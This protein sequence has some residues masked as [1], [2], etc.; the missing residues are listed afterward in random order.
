MKREGDCAVTLEFDHDYN[1]AAASSDQAIVQIYTSSLQTVHTYTGDST[2][3]KSFSIGGLLGTS[4][5]F[6]VDFHFVSA[7][8]GFTWRVDN[9]K[10]TG[11]SWN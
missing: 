11:V 3:H 10:V 5:V 6:Y 9:V 2:G 1:D 7:T 8:Q 4:G